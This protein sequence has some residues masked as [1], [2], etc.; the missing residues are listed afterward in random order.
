[1]S[2]A[3][4]LGNL[5]SAGVPANRAWE[6]VPQKSAEVAA[7]WDFAVTVG[8]PIKI[9]MQQIALLEQSREKQ[10]LELEQAIALPKATRSLMLWLPLFGLFLSQGFGLAP[11][12]AFLNPLGIGTS[13]LAIGLLYL[14]N[15]KS[16]QLLLESET[17]IQV[18]F[19]LLFFALALQAGVGL[20]MAKKLVA[21]KV[22]LELTGIDEVFALAKQTGAPLADL[23]FTKAMQ[24]QQ[25]SFTE[26][27]KKARELSVKLLIPLGLTTLPAFLLLTVVPVL[28]SQLTNR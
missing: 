13:L 25:E 1:M 27:V 23:L 18:N 19:V 8:A 12:S 22:N 15:K 17:P 24:Q 26:A 6:L 2:S 4:L 14:G 20:S 16:K 28:I 9:A 21:Q 11:F 7:V 3:Q 10:Q 5:L